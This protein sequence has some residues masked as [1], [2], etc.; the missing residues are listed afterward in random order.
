MLDQ[1]RVTGLGVLRSA[2]LTNLGRINVVSGPNNSGKSTLLGGLVDPKH[3]ARSIMFDQAA[4]DVIV[5]AT[6]GGTGDAP[7]SRENATYAGI[8][9][10]TLTGQV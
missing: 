3:R 8:I 7:Q 1:V 6:V 2:V 10:G 9:R 5:T 4:V